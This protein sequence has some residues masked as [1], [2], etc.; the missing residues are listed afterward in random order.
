MTPSQSNSVTATFNTKHNTAPFLQIKP[1]DY[2]PAFIENIA[3]AKTEID[4]IITNPEAATFENTI[5]ALDFSG[6]SL[7][8]LSS[9]F[10]NLN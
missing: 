4:A 7:D 8:R 10:F 5:V 9:I 1:T 3:K 6:E 2:K